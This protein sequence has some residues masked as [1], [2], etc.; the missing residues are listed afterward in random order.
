M[1]MLEPNG[2]NL[3][4]ETADPATH[5]AIRDAWIDVDGMPLHYLTGGDGPPLVLVHG[6]RED[7]H[8]WRW[9]LPALV[10]TYRV[11]VPD[12][13]GH[14]E[15]T[16][17]KMY[18]TPPSFYSNSLAGFLNALSVERAVLVGSSDG[19][20]TVLRVAL[21]TSGRVTALVLVDSAGL[22][23]A[24]NPALIG[25]TIPAIGESIIAWWSTP[26]GAVQ[27]VLMFATLNFGHPLL[28]PPEWLAYQYRLAL[29]PGHLH[30]AVLASSRGQLGP[31]G[32]REVYSD[33]LARLTMP[34]L[35]IWGMN[36]IV[37]PS[38]H[39][40]AAV[41]KVKN[42]QLVLIPNCGH[43]PQV[44]HPEKFI[45]ALEQFLIES[46]QPNVSND[47]VAT[48]DKE[49]HDHWQVTYSASGRPYEDY[50]AAYRYGF[51]AKGSG[52]YQNSDWTEIEPHLRRDWEKGSPD[53]SWDKV[54]DAVRFGTERGN[55]NN[56]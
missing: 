53:N 18:S 4:N 51:T 54:K 11:Y 27:W 42:S 55:G 52:R 19:G 15:S 23:A 29:T 34:T 41:A 14:G 40:I 50:D 12:L 10:R 24:V 16:K 22:G 3:G 30:E 39:A 48:T 31:F 9:V 38:V 45:M 6:Q 32:Q 8:L 33:D 17:H 1:K 44:Q 2:K 13:P 36:D 20:L 37:T 43:L 5:L 47:N 28:A 56:K 49:F 26:F 35:T 46:A 7:C 25:L 21:A